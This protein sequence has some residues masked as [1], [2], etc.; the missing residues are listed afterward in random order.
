[1][2][3]DLGGVVHNATHKTRLEVL[4]DRK[5]EGAGKDETPN[6]TALASLADLPCAWMSQEAA[7]TV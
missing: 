3:A 7:F 4:L 6:V 5:T 2:L 1:M